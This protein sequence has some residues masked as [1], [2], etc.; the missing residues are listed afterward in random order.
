MRSA[1]EFGSEFSGVGLLKS[2]QQVQQRSLARA[3]M[4]Q[5]RRDAG[6]N[7][8]RDVAQSLA[9]PDAFQLPQSVVSSRCPPASRSERQQENQYRRGERRARHRGQRRDLS[10]VHQVIEPHRHRCHADGRQNG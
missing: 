1:V 9:Q 5:H 3:G 10:V 2:D 4:S 6:L 7:A 8:Q